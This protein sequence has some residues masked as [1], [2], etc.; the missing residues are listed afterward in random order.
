MA[1]DTCRGGGDREIFLDQ[2]AARINGVRDPAW[3]PMTI[4]RKLH[5]TL[6]AG[7][8]GSYVVELVA[9]WTLVMLLTGIYL[10]WPQ[11]WQIGGV[12]APR[13]K[14]SGQ[15]VLARSSC[16]AF[17]LQRPAGGFF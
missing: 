3:Q 9:C 1:G 7:D 12:V 17:H 14:A 10:W 13:L 2:Y 4:A 6:L 16:R 15:A 5:G 8:A 11:R